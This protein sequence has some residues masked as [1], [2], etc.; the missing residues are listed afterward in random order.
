LKQELAVVDLLLMNVNK[1]VDPVYGAKRP[2]TVVAI[3]YLF[4]I[5]A[6]QV[7][8][9]ISKFASDSYQLRYS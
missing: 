7:N 4:M 6:L 5:L 2:N 9:S 3:A 8:L 1:F